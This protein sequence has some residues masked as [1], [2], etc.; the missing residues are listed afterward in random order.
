MRVKQ[1]INKNT[2]KVVEDLVWKKHA[3]EFHWVLCGSEGVRTQYDK[4]ASDSDFEVNNVDRRSVKHSPSWYLSNSPFFGMLRSWSAQRDLVWYSINGE[5]HGRRKL[6]R[7]SVPKIKRRNGQE[8]LNFTAVRSLTSEPRTTEQIGPPTTHN[9]KD[10][11]FYTFTKVLEDS[12][13]L[14]GIPDNPNGTSIS[15]NNSSHKVMYLQ[16][17]C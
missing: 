9:F 11:R 8:N 16:V 13:R 12:T 15:L 6:K 4:S 17:T 10:S 1:Q 14:Q 2:Q 3:L 7:N 5:K